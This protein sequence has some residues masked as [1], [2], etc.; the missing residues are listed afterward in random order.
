MRLFDRLLDLLEDRRFQVVADALALA[1]TVAAV[2]A[3]FL[4]G[5]TPFRFWRVVVLVYA[6]PWALQVCLGTAIAGYGRFRGMRSWRNFIIGYILVV[7]G[8][9][10]SAIVF[11]VWCL[12]GLALPEEAEEGVGTVMAYAIMAVALFTVVPGTFTVLFSF[13]GSGLYLGG[14]SMKYHV[15]S[16]CSAQVNEWSIPLSGG[17]VLC[18]RCRTRLHQG[19]RR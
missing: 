7:G 10:A 14:G 16:A 2:I 11:G 5:P 12:I 8:S 19:G 6:A 18:P 3:C 9:L 1:L 13:F 15:C 4:D 17:S